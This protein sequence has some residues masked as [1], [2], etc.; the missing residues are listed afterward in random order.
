MI[1]RIVRRALAAVL[2]LA[3]LAPPATADPTT[4]LVV[5]SGQ[6]R[7][8]PSG[9]TVVLNASSTAGASIRL[10]PG[11][12]PIAPVNGDCWTTT[13]GL[14][15]RISGATVG[16]Y[17][18]S[19]AAGTVTSV[20]VASANGVSGSVATATTTPAITLALGAITPS[21]VAASGTITGSNLSGTNTGDQNLAPYATT[22]AVAAGYQPLD[23][24]L[25]S[26][27]GLAGG[28]GLAKKTSANTWTL[29]TSTYLT[30]NQS[31][32]LSGD[33]GGT[34][35]TSI[36]TTVTKI[37]GTSLAGLGTGILKNTTT[38]GV[39]SIAI[40]ADFPTLNQNT[41]GS[42]ASFTGSLAGDVTGTQG[43][44]VVGKING[45]SLAGLAT[46]I[47]K[48]TTT[49]GTPSIAVAGDFP[50]L[51]QSTT[52]SAA[53][54][55][56]SRNFSITGGGITASTVG[57]NGSAAVVLSASVDAGH[58][59]LAR[60][61]PVA[62]STVFYRKT[63]GSGD[64]EV[65]TLA[66]LKTDL[67]L[68]GTNSG[69][70][71]I[72]LT[73]PVTG[74]GTG[75]FATTIG[76]NVV[77]RAMLSATGGA[78][79]L[80][81]TAA[82]NV[83]DLT[84]AQAKTFL[85]VTES[86]V[87]SLTTD[88]GLKAPLASPTLTGT[89]AA[90]TASAGT[91]TTQ[92]ATTAFVTTADNLKAPLASPTFTG[93]VTLPADQYVMSSDGNARFYFTGGAQSTYRSADGRHFFTDSVGT[94]T[95][96]ITNAGNG[97]FTGTVTATNVLSTNSTDIAAK[98]AGDATLTALAA[99]NTNGLLA[100]TAADT[101]AGR[102]LTAGSTKLTVTNG[103]GVSGNPTVDIGTLTA[104]DIPAIAE[105]GVTSLVSDLAL[106]APIASPTFTGTPAAP[107]A[108]GGT[109]TTQLAT[110]A[111]VATSFA[112]LASPTLTGTPA[113]P[114]AVAGTST[115]QVATTAFVATSYAPIAN[116]VFTGV[117]YWQQGAPTAVNSTA[118]LTIANI[119]TG[120]ITTTSA[121]AVALTLPTGTLTDA[122]R[123]R[124]GGRPDVR[125]VHDQPRQ[126]GRR[127]HHDRRHRP[128]DRRQRGLRDR[129][130][131]PLGHPQDRDQHLRHLSPRLISRPARSAR[132]PHYQPQERP[133]RNRGRKETCHVRKPAPPDR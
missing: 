80:G 96:S 55:T 128:H 124:A 42:A 33:V 129:D 56:T 76:A 25:T 115:T 92:L 36:G 101:F 66:T 46:G 99:Y 12:A 45:V 54:L 88:L 27:A 91:S 61:A 9:D 77:T 65:Q 2:A 23:G 43:A 41:S 32:T 69:D 120:I 116:P 20:S 16:P 3:L 13:G 85:A 75:S 67:G 63:A 86:D 11:T 40:A 70:Q 94:P 126:L 98:Q 30:G 117:M 38:T 49:A 4:P 82:G 44:T 100:Q 106:K 104:A 81:A 103:N 74:S 62:T 133:G 122:G 5:K 79:L 89:P 111:F 123:G 14:F 127:D 112:P 95:L 47:L 73:G 132:S 64:P 125:L 37:N 51:N 58:I 110:T 105:S 108:A 71:T 48:N 78:A 57:F 130:D 35:A 97:S 21:S 90:P 72:T 84:A 28:S 52:G 8:L 15:C 109:N 31:I 53:T 60:M 7:V 83:A 6:T 29:D 93:T 17:S 114:T 68:T 34:G 121:T 131:L 18:S 102:T 22:A 119:L 24:D 113:A 107:T 59:T 19:A 50:T 26:I 87:T 1:H 10:P 118:T 39:P